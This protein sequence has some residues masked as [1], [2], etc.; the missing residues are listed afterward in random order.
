MRKLIA[1]LIVSLS[2]GVSAQ[3][4]DLEWEAAEEELLRHFRALL[5]FDTSDPPGRELPAAVYLQ[6]VL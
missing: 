2:P 3:G 1:I 6:D 4:Y 5:Q